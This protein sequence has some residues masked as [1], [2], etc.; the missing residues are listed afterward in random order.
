MSRDHDAL[1]AAV[2]ADHEDDVPRLAFADWLE[3]H[4]RLARAEF[5]RAQVEF[6]RLTDDGSDSQPVYEFLRDHDWVTRPA[7]RWELIDAGIARRLE[8]AARIEELWQGHGQGW[9]A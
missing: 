5:I 3:E 9:L 6:A 4:D 1:A 7:A 8:L 2:R